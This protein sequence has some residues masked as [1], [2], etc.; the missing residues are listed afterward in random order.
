MRIDL[1]RVLLGAIAALALLLVLEWVWPSGGAE[2]VTVSPAHV[3]AQA[4]APA[5]AARDTSGWVAAI[6]ARPLFSINRRPPRVAARVAG[7]IQVG[8]A[9]LAGIM[10]TPSGK[11]AI[12]APDGGGKPL[13]LA[14]G[15]TVNESTIRRILPDGVV[16]ASGTVMHPTYDRS[17]PTT[18]SGGFQ[19]FTP[20]FPNPAVTPGFP[21]P[22]GFPN[23][24]F[25]GLAAPGF[26]N[27]GFQNPGL[28]NP[29]GQ[30]ADDGGQP[31]PNPPAPQLRGTMIPP[32][33]E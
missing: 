1:P 3:A 9:R 24:N 33:R 10:I 5:R 7:A 32:R 31:N 14:E 6:L 30:A 8:Q 17:R 2:G 21:N 20:G 29:N 12:F 23:P 13:V 27:P 19:P 4:R 11:R 28:Q 26:Q 16:L 18:G 15:A 22:G 25:P